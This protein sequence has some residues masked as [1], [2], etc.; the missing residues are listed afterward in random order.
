MKRS[1]PLSTLFSGRRV[2]MQ[3]FRPR[4][5][6]SPNPVGG[7]CV[8]QRLWNA[9]FFILFFICRIGISNIAC[10]ISLFGDI[11]RLGM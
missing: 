2:R 7:V 10:C 4:P 5:T 8:M 3:N 1:L 11:S 9:L 6:V